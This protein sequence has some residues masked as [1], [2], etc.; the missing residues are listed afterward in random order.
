MNCFTRWIAICLLSVAGCCFAQAD[1]TTSTLIEE[2]G[3]WLNRTEM[4]VP[5]EKLLNFLDS[6]KAAHFT[7]VY[8]DTLF[9]G[10]VIYPESK[11][12]PQFEEVTEPDIL[13]WLIP[14][15]K[16][17][18]MRAEAWLEYG[19]YAFHTKD[20]TQTTDRGVF[21]SKHPELTAIASDG[22]TYIHNINW[23]DFFSLCP[24]N[25]L[26]HKLLTDLYIEV[27]QRYPFDG[28]NL[29]R[30][31]FPNENFCYCAYCRENFKKDTGLE[32]K[33]FQEGTPEYQKFVLW[34]EEQLTAFMK[35]L[36]PAIRAARPGIAITLASLPPDMK[37]SHGQCWDRWLKEGYIDAAMP[38]L[39]G[40][41]GFNKR[42][43]IISQYPR[44]NERI[45]P[46]LDSSGLSPQKILEQI[47]YSRQQG[48]K[49]FALW[50][51]GTID[52]DLPILSANSFAQP[53][54]SPLK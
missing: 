44:W 42:I 19:F 45:F 34:R 40:D 20:A 50:Y 24:A 9:K 12:L 41:A 46:G 36:A 47:E 7:S 25:P 1:I 6:L 11:Y 14:E 35:N 10:T 17:R 18:K 28:L 31:R 30:I 5:K 38:M 13:T 53:A 32:L 49:G 29:D 48:A 4:F 3:V 39:Y 33:P 37:E 16:K 54:V 52:D 21:L 51:S 22:A 26:S 43:Q 8:I 2:R 27:A 15:I 23:G